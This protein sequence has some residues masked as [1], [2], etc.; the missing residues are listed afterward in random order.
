MAKQTRYLTPFPLLPQMFSENLNLKLDRN[1]F[2]R[3]IP[4]L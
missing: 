4:H 1:P 3:N 2:F